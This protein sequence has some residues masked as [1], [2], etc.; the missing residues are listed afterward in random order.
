M[1]TRRGKRDQRDDGG[2][3]VGHRRRVGVVTSQDS[4]LTS[5]SRLG[6]R[7]AGLLLS[8]AC[9][10]R[11]LTLSRRARLTLTPWVRLAATQAHSLSRQ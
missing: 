10:L 1:G 11:S 7:S 3:V 8:A 9:S 2:V 5:A 6:S 4:G